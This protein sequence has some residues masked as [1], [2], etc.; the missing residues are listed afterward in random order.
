MTDNT[1]DIDVEQL[2]DFIGHDVRYE[3]RDC[4]I[5]EILEDGP[6]LVLQHNTSMTT[7]QAD[8]H[9]EAHRKV[10]STITIEVMDKEKG[11]YSN[12]FTSLNLP[13]VV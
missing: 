8:Q 3:G 9:G 5:I 13:S 1:I 12:A 11:V 10:P 7:I 2:R 6:A 4:C